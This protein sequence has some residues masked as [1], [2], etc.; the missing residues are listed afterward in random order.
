MNPNVRVNE[1]CGSVFLIAAVNSYNCKI[2]QNGVI[3][4]KIES[5]PTEMLMEF[6]LLISRGFTV[7]SRVRVL[8]LP[9]DTEQKTKEGSESN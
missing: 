6:S 8:T 5:K 1:V 2:R 4:S 3:R 7:S 9:C